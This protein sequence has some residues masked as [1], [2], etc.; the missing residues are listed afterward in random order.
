MKLSDSNAPREA[1]FI[2]DCYREKDEMRLLFMCPF[3]DE[4]M[5]LNSPLSDLK[6][7]DTCSRL[8]GTLSL[9]YSLTHFQQ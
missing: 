4:S 6:I 8:D 5:L 7:V 2:A 3:D 9:S 1:Y